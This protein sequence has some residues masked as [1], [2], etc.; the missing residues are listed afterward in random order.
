MRL[1]GWHHPT[2]HS[3]CKHTLGFLAVHHLIS[4][5]GC[6]VL[7]D[8]GKEFLHCLRQQRG[9]CFKNGFRG[10]EISLG[11]MTRSTIK[12]TTLSKH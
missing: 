12:L 5:I 2:P 1:P 6:H 4:L 3:V 8:E 9:L 7:K 11:N 10:K